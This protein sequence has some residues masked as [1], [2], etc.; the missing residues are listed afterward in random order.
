MTLPDGSHIAPQAAVGTSFPTKT[1]AGRPYPIGL[2]ADQDGHIQGSLPAYGLIIPPAAVGAS[3]VFFDL[4]NASVLGVILR[5]R[6]LFAFVAADVAVTGAINVRLDT[7]RT[8][9]VGTGGT[10]ATTIPNAS[11]TAAAFWS[12]SPTNPALPLGVTARALPTAGATDDA[13]LWPSYVPTEETNAGTPLAQYFN[14]L[15]E[16]PLNQTIELPGGYGIKVQQG[17]VAGVGSVGFLLALTVE[18]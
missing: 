12:F 18:G 4:F 8:K 6:K 5:L 10:A 9:A 1:I 7:M 16:M 14:V 11:R 2:Q 3:K 15:P 17:T 13:W